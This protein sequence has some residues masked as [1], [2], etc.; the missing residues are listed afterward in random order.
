MQTLVSNPSI[1]ATFQG[2][3]RL[4]DN[5]QQRQNGRKA[6]MKT[7]K[8]KPEQYRLDVEVSDTDKAQQQ[9][10]RAAALAFSVAGNKRGAI[11]YIERDIERHEA[12]YERELQIATSRRRAAQDHLR[13]LIK[14]P[15]RPTRQKQILNGAIRILESHPAYKDGAA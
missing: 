3:S 10:E 6:K 15:Q 14:D 5:E 9:S 4:F 7:Q 11:E 1:A 8:E 2:D 13:Y 12:Q